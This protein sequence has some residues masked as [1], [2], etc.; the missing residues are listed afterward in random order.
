MTDCI[1]DETN[2][3][4]YFKEVEKGS[5]EKEDVIAVYTALAELCGG[6]IKKDIIYLL[7][8][9]PEIGAKQAITI[10]TKLCKT[11]YEQALK[12]VTDICKDL[13]DGKDYDFVYNKVYEYIIEIYYYTKAENIPENNR[14]WNKVTI[15]NYD[16]YIRKLKDYNEYINDGKTEQ[17]NTEAASL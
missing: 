17:G 3:D 8:T 4:Q 5:P 12:L 14:H 10:A 7:Q 15:Q 16:D 11:N 1:I 2:F 13:F 9:Y 6:E